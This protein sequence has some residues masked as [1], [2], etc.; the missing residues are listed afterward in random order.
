MSEPVFPE[1]PVTGRMLWSEPVSPEG[2]L[3]GRT[4]WHERMT[5]AVPH[6]LGSRPPASP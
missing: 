2:P 1:G 4:P 3:T 6:A 5:L